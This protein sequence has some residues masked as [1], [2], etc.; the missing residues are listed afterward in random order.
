MPR[1]VDLPWPSRRFIPGCGP[2]PRGDGPSPADLP[3][4]CDA[5][6]AIARGLDL[7]AAHYPWEAH[8]A[9]E[10]G[11][12]RLAPGD[13]RRAVGAVIKLCAAILRARAGDAP[14]AARLVGAARG[15]LGA[16]ARVDGV[17]VAALA[18]A[19]SRFVD[20]CA[21]GDA[22]APLDLTAARARP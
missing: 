11:W 5:P 19:V 1:R 21:R 7:L 15:A 13:E 10:V 6:T 3:A 20:A 8:E 18:D 14:A 17:E 22:V 9:L 2:H 12:R 4:G 16:G